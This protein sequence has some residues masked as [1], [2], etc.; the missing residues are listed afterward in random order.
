MLALGD[1]FT[2]I[3]PRTFGPFIGHHQELFASVK[4]FLK[5]FFKV[6]ITLLKLLKGIVGSN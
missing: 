1:E 4:S 6:F 3:V 2:E 5:S